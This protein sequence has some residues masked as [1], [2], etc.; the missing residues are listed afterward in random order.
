[1]GEDVAS[2][3]SLTR[4]NQLVKLYETVVNGDHNLKNILSLLTNDSH[5]QWPICRRCV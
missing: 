1:M 5:P 2:D 3:C 4:Y